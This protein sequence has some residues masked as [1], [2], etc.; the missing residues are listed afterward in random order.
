MPPGLRPVRARR[1]AFLAMAAGVALALLAPPAAAQASAEA[2]PSPVAPGGAVA[3]TYRVAAPLPVDLALQE[4]VTCAIAGPDG[5]SAPLCDAPGALVRVDVSPG[6]TTYA[7][8]VAAPTAPGLYTVTFTRARTLDLLGP[9][10]PSATATLLVAEAGDPLSPGGGPGDDGGS[11]GGDGGAGGGGPDGP[12][13]PD[14][15]DA[16]RWLV[17]MGMATAALA[18]MLVG[19]RWG[20]GGAP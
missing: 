14:G 7:F 11:G 9:A 3:L 8:R 16:Q 17:S 20:L 1:A 10:D 18:V 4:R 6:E 5:A 13:S 2:H 12:G 15:L 19:A